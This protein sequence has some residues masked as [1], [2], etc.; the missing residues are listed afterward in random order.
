MKNKFLDRI[1][2]LRIEL[3]DLNC[4]AILVE[5]RTDLYYLTGLE[6]SAGSLL[7]D[8][9]SA[10]LLVDGRYFE[11]CQHLSPCPVFLTSGGRNT[12]INLLKDESPFVNSLGFDS[13]QT[14]YNAYHELQK[15]L[16]DCKIE[17]RPI[18]SPVKKL[19]S[20]KDAK[21][22][23][24]LKDAGKLGGEGFD[25][26]CKL[27]KEGI[28]EIEIASEL[29]IFWK[30]KGSK[31]V[32]F[33]PIIAFGKNSSMPHYRAGFTKLKRGD[34]VLIDIGVNKDYYHSDM[35]RVV[36]FGEPDA[37]LLEVHDVVQEAQERALQMCRPGTLIGE[38]D[39][40][41]RD[42]IVEKG[43]GE[44]FPHSLGHGI[45]LEVHEWPI[46]RNVHPYKEVELQPGM[47][48][49]IEPGIYLPG[50]GGVRIEDTIVITEKGHMNLTNRP[51][52]PLRLG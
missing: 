26:V 48:I 32:A 35:T 40:A 38:L 39:E 44:S 20:I 23:A 18:K 1:E 21:E 42:L 30:R 6:L 4:N 37:R 22:I 46:L 25:L 5:N 28:S 31:G 43:F 27:L 13:E 12:L 41:A 14:S 49:T 24:L 19:R 50:I 47:V 8:T 10:F 15:S 9:Q 51:T 3:N 45:G 36:Y 2:K 17:L 29:E 33:E 7:V 16:H 52:H 11:S 34:A